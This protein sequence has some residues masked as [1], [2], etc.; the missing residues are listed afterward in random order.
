[1]EN[2]EPNTKEP[3]YIS[4]F[5]PMKIKKRGG[6]VAT[7]IQPQTQELSIDENPNYNYRLINTLTKAYKLQQKKG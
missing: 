7:I 5:I 2:I 3:N 4:I 1:M 6:N